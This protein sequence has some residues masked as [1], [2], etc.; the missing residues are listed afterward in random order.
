MEDEEMLETEEAEAV[1]EPSEEP[2]DEIIDE[3]HKNKLF[4]WLAEHPRSTFWIRLVLWT[5]C[6]CV[7]PFLFI[8]WRFELF[9]KV[10]KLQLGGWG[11]VAIL[12]VAIFV[13]AVLKYV[14]LA[15]GAKYSLTGQILKGVCKI[16]V[17]LLV[18]I[19]I[20]ICVRDSV[21]TTIKVL[22]VVTFLEFVAIPLNPLPKW[23]YDM[24]KDV[25]DEE[26]KETV[27]YFIDSFFK[28]KKKDEG[29]E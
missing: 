25:K 9:K 10:S 16:I 18:L 20:L 13:L 22:G 5:L 17:P 19:G 21:W 4:A 26:K 11:V 28:R 14:R 23:V 7:L 15:L 8:A 29:G 12:L 24:Q 1:E 3:E 6:A 2:E 27:D